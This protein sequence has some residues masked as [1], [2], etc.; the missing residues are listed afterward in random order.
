V[1]AFAREGLIEPVEELRGGFDDPGSG[2]RVCLLRCSRC[3]IEFAVALLD[4]SGAAMALYRYAD[5]VRAIAGTCLVKLLS[6][7][8]GSQA[9]YALA[10]TWCAGFA[11]R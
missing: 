6:G 11:S 4:P 10:E 5:M 8:A 9:Q 2:C 3:R 1:R 7:F